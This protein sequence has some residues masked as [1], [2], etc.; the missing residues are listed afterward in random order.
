[1]IT[2]NRPTYQLHPRIAARLCA[3]AFRRAFSWHFFSSESQPLKLRVSVNAS[4]KLEFYHPRNHRLTHIF[5]KEGG[6]AWL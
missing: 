3:D 1:M 5:P 6:E 2:T 4:S